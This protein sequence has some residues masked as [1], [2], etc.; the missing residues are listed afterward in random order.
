MIKEYTRK[1]IAARRSDRVI[2][3]RE[4]IQYARFIGYRVR[5]PRLKGIPPGCVDRDM[6]ITPRTGDLS[7]LRD[8]DSELSSF[9]GIYQVA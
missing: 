8:R 5:T 6:G 2:A 4:R 9:V 3:L 7:L 1:R